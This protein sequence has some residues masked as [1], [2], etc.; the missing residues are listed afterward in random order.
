MNTQREIK[1]VCFYYETGDDCS[2]NKCYRHNKEA[3]CKIDGL[4]IYLCKF[5]RKQFDLFISQHPDN[6]FKIRFK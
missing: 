6:N 3:H 2:E 5:C 1:P 4:D